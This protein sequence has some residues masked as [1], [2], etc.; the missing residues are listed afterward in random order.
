MQYKQKV[1]TGYVMKFSNV[2]SRPN[3]TAKGFTK[4]YERNSQ[5]GKE[6]KVSMSILD[7]D[8]IGKLTVYGTC[9]VLAG[10]R[11]AYFIK[12]VIIE[13]PIDKGYFKKVLI[14]NERGK[15]KLRMLKRLKATT[16]IY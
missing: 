5:L 10:N 7:T 8:Y 15:S 1:K 14:L 16:N 11:F 4:H 12:T 13:H 9:D 6:R 3:K 2:A